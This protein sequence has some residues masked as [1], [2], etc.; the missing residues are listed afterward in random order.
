MKTKFISTLLAL[1]MAAGYLFSVPAFA[2]SPSFSGGS[3]T[4][5]D[6]YLI[7]TAEDMWELSNDCNSGSKYEKKYAS[8]YFKMTEDIDLGCSAAKQW[9]PIGNYDGRVYFSGDFNGDGHTITG[10][11]IDNSAQNQGLFGSTSQST[12]RNLN[13]EGT[14]K[15]GS[16]V[17]GINAYSM[18]DITINNCSFKGSVY[19]KDSY[20]GGI[21]AYVSGGNLKNCTN[22]ATVTAGGECVGG[23]AGTGYCNISGCKNMGAVKGTRYV[24]GISGNSM[25]SLANGTISDCYNAGTIT[26]TGSRIGG[27][28]G[29]YYMNGSVTKCYNT[30]DVNGGSEVGGIVGD[31]SPD[32]TVSSCFNI[33]NI[34]GGSEI[35]GISGE[36]CNGGVV[37]NCY[38]TGDVT[39]TSYYAGGIIGYHYAGSAGNSGSTRIEFAYNI[40]TV[41]ANSSY[42]SIAGYSRNDNFNSQVINTVYLQGSCSQNKYG[43]QVT[44]EQLANTATYSS[45]NS[46]DSIWQIPD[47]LGRPI[48]LNP[49]ETVKIA[50]ADDMC[51]LY[52]NVQKGNTYKNIYIELTDDIDFDG[53]DW[54]PIG[55]YDT[56]EDSARPF[57]GNF[58][59]NGHTI[60]NL[61]CDAGS[62]EYQGLF[63][64]VG[65]GGQVRNVIMDDS[66]F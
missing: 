56:D 34:S 39:A 5:E 13:V 51:K 41:T 21:A 18:S 27:I 32:E 9:I 10:L 54:L 16:R 58:N 2:D 33:G 22:E 14:V 48:L 30:G 60:S 53:Y 12:V 29:Q 44:K 63:G 3:G 46:F 4:E 7:S 65:A 40:G 42:D 20:A 57:L 50:T 11:Y 55:S 38:N 1:S 15:G 31:L 43:T 66:C 45:W 24:A 26:G 49:E 35:G 62:E 52:E 59:G 23:I 25:S 36:L 61:N 28:V 17:A 8:K 6:P 47:A 64:Y 19:A 37:K